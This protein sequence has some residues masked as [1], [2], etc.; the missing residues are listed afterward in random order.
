MV[1]LRNLLFLLTLSLVGNVS[2]QVQRRISMGNDT[3]QVKSAATSV[4]AKKTEGEWVSLGTG[5]L[6]DD[7]IT[8]IYMV[9]PLE[10]DVEIQESATTPGLYR[11]VNAYKDYPFRGG[12]WTEDTYMEIDATDPDHVYFSDHNTKV[13]FGDGDIWVSSI[14]GYEI[15]RNGRDKEDVFAEGSAGTLKQGTIT[16]PK[17]MLLATVD[18]TLSS[19]MIANEFEKF[20]VKLPGAPDL[21]ITITPGEFNEED[22]TLSVAVSVGSSCEK[23]RIGMFEGDYLTVMTNSLK[24]G[25][26]DYKEIT[27]SGEVKFPLEADGVYT[28]V[29]LPY[30]QGEPIDPTIYTQ[31]FAYLLDG[32]TSLGMAKYKE[33]ILCDLDKE[34]IVGLTSVEYDVEIQEST[35]IPGFYRLVD[36]YAV[37]VYPY[38]TTQNFD[39]SHKHYLEFDATDPDCVLIKYMAD[40]CGL[41]FGGGIMEIWS[42]ADRDIE[43]NGKSKETV[44]AEG[45]Y[46]GTLKDGVLTFPK[47]SLLCYFPMFLAYPYWGNCTNQFKLTMPEGYTGI[48]RTTTAKENNKVEYFTLDGIKV[49]AS[50]LTHGMYIVR[51]GNK[52]YKTIVR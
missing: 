16:F 39:S 5:K 38:A 47:E 19:Y 26:A 41:D 17:N 12:E 49:P 34:V 33:G 8:K 36:P 52:S 2:A 28:F 50:K 14:A 43:E 24:D 1:F 10:W 13:N 45:K 27:A 37:D 42:K 30:Y 3:Y 22:N 4:N 11:I 21:D 7:M 6:R 25:S 44:K 40:G 32:W 46:G 35:D 20:R 18:Q 9:D 23:V 48:E 31:E 29:A 51:Q 15:T